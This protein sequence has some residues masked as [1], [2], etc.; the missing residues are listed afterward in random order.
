DV[1]GLL[2]RPEKFVNVQFL[3][4]PLLRKPAIDEGHRPIPASGGGSNPL[5]EAIVQV[6]VNT[7][8]CIQDVW[9]A[10]GKPIAEVGAR[11]REIEERLTFAARRARQGHQTI[12]LPL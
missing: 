8:G 4:E 7:D 5:G 6:D 12:D 9:E 10:I 2:D 3:P 1:R 11:D